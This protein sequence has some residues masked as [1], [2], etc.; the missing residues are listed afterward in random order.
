MS[1]LKT[2]KIYKATGIFRI[3]T[4]MVGKLMTSIQVNVLQIAIKT[5]FKQPITHVVISSPK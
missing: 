2:A 5:I 1:P 4:C 3:K